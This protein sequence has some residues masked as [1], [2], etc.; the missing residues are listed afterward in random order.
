MLA[1]PN[2]GPRPGF[3][4]IV[5]DEEELR[6]TLAMMVEKAGWIARPCASGAELLLQLD[7]THPACIVLDLSMPIANGFEVQRELL[8]R[9]VDVPVIFLT[10]EGT[11]PS[12]VRALRE[13]ALDFIEKPVPMAVLIE[14]IEN[15]L[16]QDARRVGLASLRRRIS[17]LTKREIEI[18]DL[19]ARGMGSKQI[20]RGLSISVRTVE[21]HRERILMKTETANTAEFVC[22]YASARESAANS[23]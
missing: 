19:L 15:A 11:I 12:A 9:D 14:A 4:Y 20:G 8:L 10:G 13:G 1:H 18:G 2:H 6:S 16:L 23:M 22:L 7:D 21:H 5:D 3:V 17:S